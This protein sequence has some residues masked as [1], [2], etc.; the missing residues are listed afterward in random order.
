MIWAYQMFLINA[1]VLLWLALPV[2]GQIVT[3]G[4]RRVGSGRVGFGRPSAAQAATAARVFRRWKDCSAIWLD[5]T[6]WTSPECRAGPLAVL[7]RKRDREAYGR[8]GCLTA[9]QSGMAIPWPESGV[10]GWLVSRL[11]LRVWAGRAIPPS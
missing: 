4:N 11:R 5:G 9:A 6:S 8:A 1:A 10:A 3:L 7:C 2:P